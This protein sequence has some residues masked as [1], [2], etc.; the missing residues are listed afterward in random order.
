M[1][2]EEERTGTW[3]A[4]G[5]TASSKAQSQSIRNSLLDRDKLAQFKPISLAGSSRFAGYLAIHFPEVVAGIEE[6]DLGVLHLEVAALKMA[7]HDAIH[8][9]DWLAVRKHF[10]FIDS[11]LEIAETELHDAI[12]VSYLVNLFYNETSINFAKA[13]TLLPKR[14]AVALE[15]MERHYEEL[16]F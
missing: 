5:K 14:L 4:Y 12:G 9:R 8:K 10:A 7:T 6:A 3:Y 11:V 16:K 15:I 2:F 1:V 13:R